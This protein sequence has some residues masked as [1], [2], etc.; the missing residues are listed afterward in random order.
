MRCAGFVIAVLLMF[1]GCAAPAAAEKR[2]ALIIGNSAYEHA[3]GLVN[4]VTDARS[5]RATLTKIGFDDANIIYGENLTKRDFERAVARFATS[6]RD[7]DV[8]VIF[9]AGH[10]ST[11][12]GIPYA[13]PVD[14]QFTSLEGMPYE[15]VTLDSMIGELR[16]AKGIGIAIFDACRDNGAEQRLKRGPASRGVEASRGLAPPANA[17]G[18]IVAFSTGY[19]ATAADGAP[20]TNSPYTAALVQQL[21]TPGLDVV[22]LFRNVGRQV[23]EQT[24]GR[25]NPALQID[26][27]YEHYAL[28][29]APG[30]NSA[31]K[32]TGA[33][34]QGNAGQPVQAPPRVPPGD[35]VAV[36]PPVTT[37]GVSLPR[38][39]PPDL[40]S[41]RVQPSG[42]IFPDSH[43]RLLSSDEISALSPDELRIA[44]N[45]I[46]A[47]RGIYFKSPDL[48]A[49]FGKFSWYRPNTWN[50]ALSRIEEQN[51]ARLQQ[52]EQLYGAASPSDKF[53]SGTIAGRSADFIFPDSDQ[54]LLSRSEL[55]GLSTAELRIARNEIYA[56]R[57][58]LFK[59]ADLR[60]RFAKFS[61]YRPYTSE[62]TLNPVESQNVSL[63]QQVEAGR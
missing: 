59:S 44:R 14:A 17:D 50:P 29:T 63:I 33:A 36:L 47:R 13:V 11:F 52:H 16:R 19:N 35:Q 49:H 12:G 24:G 18:L 40:S 48:Q 6:A 10:G 61:W 31:P 30:G 60:E 32:P 42:F 22:D 53:A 25:Q 8:A 26:G 58:M 34:V 55:A 21:L 51:V 9:Y 1:Y 4:P 56:R 28:V 5:I 15:L 41:P 3:D 43:Q 27:F 46:F 7:S 62:P 37:P 57:G 54:R 20:G 39:P 38:V 23:K 2:V 45:E